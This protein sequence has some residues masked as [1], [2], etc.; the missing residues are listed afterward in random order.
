MCS[1]VQ[2]SVAIIDQIDITEMRVVI[3]FAAVVVE[4]DQILASRSARLDVGVS[5]R[6]DHERRDIVVVEAI[7]TAIACKLPNVPQT[8]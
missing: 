8:A 1:S 5:V 6:A 4:V 2:E 3:R 7:V